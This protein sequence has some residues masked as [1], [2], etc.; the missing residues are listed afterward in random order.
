MNVHKM[1]G[2]L[3]LFV[4]LVIF[5]PH[6][7]E[8]SSSASSQTVEKTFSAR[9]IQRLVVEERG[10]KGGGA[11]INIRGADTDQIVVAMT[12]YTGGSDCLTDMGIDGKELYIKAGYPWEPTRLSD[13]GEK[14]CRVNLDITL[15]KRMLVDLKIGVGNVTLDNLEGDLSATLTAGNLKGNLSSSKAKLDLSYG[16]ADLQ[17]NKISKEGSFQFSSSMS[18]MTLR[19]P[20]GA[21]INPNGIQEGQGSSVNNKVTAGKESVFS[22]SGKVKMGAVSIQYVH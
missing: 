10:N 16:N 6:L 19:F 8:A 11:A 14:E 17:W 9:D 3:A 5:L 20:Q 22:V 1:N 7:T 18:A 15:P 2:R 12:K 13:K 21:V 4:F